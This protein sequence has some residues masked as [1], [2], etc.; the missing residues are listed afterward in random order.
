MMPA[1]MPPMRGTEYDM[2]NDRCYKCP[3]CPK[4]K[5]PIW[6]YEDE[7]YHCLSC[8]EIVEIDEEMREWFTVREETKIEIK[9]CPHFELA[10]GSHSMG[11]GGKNCVETHYGRNPVTLEWQVLGGKCRKCGMSFLV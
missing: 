8:G 4:C 3:N 9:D 11:C 5:V 2:P 7:Q 6:K 1:Q 10:D